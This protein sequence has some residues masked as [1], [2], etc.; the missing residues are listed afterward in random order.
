[1]IIPI[2]KAIFI[3]SILISMNACSLIYD[4]SQGKGGNTEVK[5]DPKLKYYE[6]NKR[7]ESNRIMASDF[8]VTYK[9]R[10]LKQY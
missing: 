2:S 5:I 8:P 7:Y 9:A 3:S 10:P 4:Q 6:E 1:M